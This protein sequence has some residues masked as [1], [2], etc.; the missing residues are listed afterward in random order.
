MSTFSSDDILA[1]IQAQVIYMIMRV[2]DEAAEPAS[3]N[4]DMLSAF[5]VSIANRR[6]GGLEEVCSPSTSYFASDFK[7][8][9][10][11]NPLT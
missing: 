7:R 3:L 8:W 1:A 11:I 4:V 6:R 9:A 2:V 5:K 10:M